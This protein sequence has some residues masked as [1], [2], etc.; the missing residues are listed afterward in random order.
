V[1]AGTSAHQGGRNLFQ[2]LHQPWAGRCRVPRRARPGRRDIRCPRPGRRHD[3]DPVRRRL[4]GC[5]SAFGPGKRARRS[6]TVLRAG[7]RTV[8][9]LLPPRCPAPLL[10]RRVGR[11]GLCRDAHRLPAVGLRR[12]GTTTPTATGW[13]PRT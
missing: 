9:R 7:G 13:L 10:R 4:R 6:R 1:G 2:P 3:L 11:A 5:R 12:A 8:P